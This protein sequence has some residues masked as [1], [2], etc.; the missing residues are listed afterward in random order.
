MGTKCQQHDCNYCTQDE[1]CR[2]RKKMTLKE[3]LELIIANPQCP[4]LKHCYN[5]A[6]LAYVYSRDG[7]LA[8]LRIQL[9]YVVSNMARWR[10]GKTTTGTAEQIKECRAVIRERCK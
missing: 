2:K 6:R 4:A 9:L 10:A 5:Y 1:S 7:Q 3:A 8:E